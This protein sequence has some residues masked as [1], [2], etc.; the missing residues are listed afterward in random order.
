MIAT[1]ARLLTYGDKLEWILRRPVTVIL[2]VGV[3]SAFF[4]WRTVLV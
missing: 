3:V 2:F 4:A 1:M